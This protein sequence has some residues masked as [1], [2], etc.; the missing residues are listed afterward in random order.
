MPYKNPETEQKYDKACREA[1]KEKCLA[2]GKAYHEANKAALNRYSR[3]YYKAYYQKTKEAQSEHKAE[4]YKNTKAARLAYGKKHYQ[5]NKAMYIA[6]CTS[7]RAAKQNATPEWLTSACYQQIF[8][9]YM[10][11]QR[12]T[13]LT[14]IQFHVDHIVPLQGETVC[15]LHVPWNLQVIPQYENQSKKNKLLC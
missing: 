1:N 13:T 2:Y 4:Y 5:N 10:E 7:R 14:G 12:L 3:A 8:N 6:N 11:A 9:F 15:G